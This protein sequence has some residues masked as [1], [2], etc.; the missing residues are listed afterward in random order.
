MKSNKQDTLLE[1]ELNFPNDQLPEWVLHKDDTSILKNG[2]IIHETGDVGEKTIITPQ[3]PTNAAPKMEPCFF[4]IHFNYGNTDYTADV[5]KADTIVAEYHVTGVSPDV[6]HLPD[7]FIVTLHFS[8][9]K[10]DFPV[11]EKYYPQVFGLA[12]V[13]AIHKGYIQKERSFE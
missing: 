4:P 3:S 1:P 9:G 2:E 5:K 8:G 6:D 10:Y 13:K 7:P 12:V 11:N